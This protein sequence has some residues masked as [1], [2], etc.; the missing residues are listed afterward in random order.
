[1][2][3]SVLKQDPNTKEKKERKKKNAFN[4]DKYLFYQNKRTDFNY[5]KY[6][7]YENIFLCQKIN[8][9]FFFFFTFHVF[10]SFDTCSHIKMRPLPLR[11]ETFAKPERSWHEE[12]TA[13][14][15]MRG[16]DPLLRSSSG[17]LPPFKKILPLLL[18]PLLLFILRLTLKIE[19]ITEGT[20]EQRV[21]QARRICPYNSP[22]PSLA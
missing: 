22:F 15:G 9:F 17:F 5:D 10:G 11:H 13:L 1:M 20:K 6:L 2:T 4:Y 21:F 18:P 14:L 7:F 16:H 3:A 19:L 8:F 12:E